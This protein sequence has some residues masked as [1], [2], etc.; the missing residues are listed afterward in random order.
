MVR[1][2]RGQCGKIH[3]QVG[4]CRPPQVVFHSKIFMVAI[5]YFGSK[6]NRVPRGRD[7]RGGV[8]RWLRK[9]ET[10]EH[11]QSLEHGGGLMASKL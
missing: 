8:P 4:R 2:V 10:I 9:D 6:A 3:G 5:L 11:L 1:Q 7:G